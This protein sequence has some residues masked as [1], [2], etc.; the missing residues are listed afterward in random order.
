M[1]ALHAR[2]S[3]SITLVLTLAAGVSAVASADVTS[4]SATGDAAAITP[5]V[6]EFKAA[7]GQ[8]NPNAPGSVG[9][10]RRE[11]NWDGVPDTLSSP[12]VFPGDFFNF[13][14]VGRARGAAFTLPE[15]AH[16]EVS[17]KLGNPDGAP[18][19]FG[20]IDPSYVDSFATFSPQRLFAP[21]GS[22]TYT[23]KFFIPGTVT[24][25]AGVTGFG[26][27]FTDV[28]VAFG[29]TI[30]AFDADGAILGSVSAPHSGGSG[31]L[32]FA[33]IT[34]TGLN[35]I[36]SLEIKS[37]TLPLGPGNVDNAR[38]DLDVV[39]IDDLIYGEPTNL[40]CI[41]DLNGDFD[42]GA[43]DLAILLGAWGPVGAHPADFNGD[44][45]VG[46]WDIA[47]LLGL[48]GPCN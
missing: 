15:G 33:G 38:N 17:A 40:T 3:R 14:T 9:S 47:W 25:P 11:I 37:G 21:V 6:N 27:V 26:A 18:V 41:A 31:L 35:R 24:A 30:T 13:T 32:S 34:V 8:L 7:L 45:I 4:Y 16:F 28:D 48:W 22:T 23:T 12:H 2:H 39:A 5:I 43:Q 1:N 19:E 20:N 46:A 29:T 42:V 36:A 10:G 44:G